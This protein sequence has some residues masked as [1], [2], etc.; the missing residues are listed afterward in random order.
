MSRSYKRAI[1]KICPE[2]GKEGK[3]AANRKVRRTK[4]LLP[5]KGNHYRKLYSSYEIHDWVSDMRFGKFKN[6]L[7]RGAKYTGKGWVIPK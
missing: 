5:P 4:N 2:S 7:P 3:K 6:R 1:M